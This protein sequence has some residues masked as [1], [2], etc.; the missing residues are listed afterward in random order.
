VAVGHTDD[1]TPLPDDTDDTDTDA[2]PFP[3]VVVMPGQQTIDPELWADPALVTWQSPITDEI[4]VAALDPTTGGWKAG[5][6]ERLDLGLGAPITDDGDRPGTLNGPEFG[7]GGRMIFYTGIA[8]DASNQIVVWEQGGG[9]RFLTPADGVHRSG[10]LAQ[11]EPGGDRVAYLYFRG[12]FQDLDF[13]WRWVDDDEEHPFASSQS[14]D[15]TPRWIPGED[16]FAFLR[17]DDD[18]NAQIWR[19]ALADGA[20]TQLT[21]DDGDKTDPFIVPDPAGGPRILAGTTMDEAPP[22]LGTLVPNR[23]A[24][25]RESG[26]R[27]E[28]VRTIAIEDFVGGGPYTVLS[29]EPFV[30]GDEVWVS[31]TATTTTRRGGPGQVY[32]ANTDGSQVIQ[33]TVGE[34]K[35]RSDPETV[36]VNGRAFLYYTERVA[37]TLTTHLVRDFLPVTP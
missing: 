1:T 9:K 32:V 13:V 34:G 24:V 23:L 37:G 4:W 26:D 22:D 29:P 25:Y 15:P 3:D 33:L 6:R 14:S 31:F 27:F 18:G 30:L 28:P 2:T 8:E 17:D 11:L 36:V 10:A 35:T 16:A 20:I 7:D 12:R 21:F 19:Y 5:A